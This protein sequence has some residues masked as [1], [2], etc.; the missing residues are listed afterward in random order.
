[1]ISEEN[2][3]YKGR[4][5]KVHSHYDFLENSDDSNA[6][7]TQVKQMEAGDE[8]IS[9]KRKTFDSDYERLQAERGEMMGGQ[10]GGGRNL[11]I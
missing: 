10:M 5:H 2:D 9:E 7:Y 1:M 3:D 8:L 4:R 11:M 6:V